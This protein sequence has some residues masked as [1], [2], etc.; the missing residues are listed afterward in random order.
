MRQPLSQVLSETGR[1]DVLV[2]GAGQAGLTAA[3]AAAQQGARVLV[4][5]KLPHPGGSTA[6]SSGLTAYAGTDEQRALGIEDSPEALKA[7]ILATGQHRNDEALVDVYCREQLTTYR[8]LKELGVEYGHVHAASGQSVPRSH[9]TDPSRMIDTLARRAEEL[10]VRIIFGVRAFQLLVDDGAVTGVLVENGGALVEVEAGS[11]VIATGGFSRN[12]ELLDRFVPQMVH[13]IHGGSPGSEG[14]GLLMAWKAGADFRDTPYVK[15]TFGIHPGDD[16][17][18][19]GTGIL[20]VYKGAIAVDVRGRRFTDESKPYKEIGDAC[21]ALP[22]HVAWQVFDQQTMDKDDPEVHIYWFSGRLATGLL[23]KADTVE[24]LAERIGVPA[25][26]L[27]RTVDDYN[28]AVRGERADQFGRTSL[29]GTSEPPTEISQGP[30]YAHLSGAS[31]LATYCG[32]TVD[33]ETQVL[34][35]YGEPI[36]GL[37]AAGEVTGGFHGAGY[38]TGTSVGKSG[39]F[40][41]LSGL[42][43]AAYA[44]VRA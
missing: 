31:V 43:A 38:V 34:D 39:V 6:M 10:G 12:L 32:L 19:N 2:L 7:D 13:A 11:V 15:G 23:E 37:Y 8:W 4:L 44:G 36:P 27:R 21:L 30:F 9:A 35:V 28:A 29:S 41:R 17:R 33:A 20:A 42:A 16:P 5:E 26:E 40:G 24:E 25:D 18:E 14:D 22:E 1:P 3:V